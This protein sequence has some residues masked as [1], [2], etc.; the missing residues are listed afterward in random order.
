[1][2][3]SRHGTCI[4]MWECKRRHLLDHDRTSGSQPKQ[5]HGKVRV[6]YATW[7]PHLHSQN[8]RECEG[9]YPHTLSGFP[10]WELESLWNPKFS[11]NDFKVQ[12]SLD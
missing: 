8:A 11:E 6:E 9:M 1:M 4:L 3:S 5:G 7:E 2:N 10:L 12:N